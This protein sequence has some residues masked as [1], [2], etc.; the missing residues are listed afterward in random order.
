MTSQNISSLDTASLDS[1]RVFLT[2]SCLSLLFL[3][4]LL[5]AYISLSSSWFPASLQSRLSCFH[6]HLQHFCQ[7]LVLILTP[8]CSPMDFVCTETSQ[9]L[10]PRSWLILCLFS[11]MQENV[12]HLLNDCLCWWLENIVM[13]FEAFWL[14]CWI[15]GRKLFMSFFSLLL[16]FKTEVGT[17]FSTVQSMYCTCI[18]TRIESKGGQIRWFANNSK[19]W[20]CWTT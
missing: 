5:S 4:N 17:F 3:V 14:F 19:H 18:Y 2:Q 6:T 13:I 16:L 9:Y 8:L 10:F 20:K 7:T 12:E 11:E 15:K 1:S